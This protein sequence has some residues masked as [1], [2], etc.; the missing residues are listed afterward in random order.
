MSSSFFSTS[1]SLVKNSQQLNHNLQQKARRW[2]KRLNQRSSLKRSKKGTRRSHKISK[3]TS[4]ASLLTVKKSKKQRPSHSLSPRQHRPSLMPVLLPLRTQTANPQLRAAML[5]INPLI[6]L[7]LPPLMFPRYISVYWLQMSWPLEEALR[8]CLRLRRLWFLSP[9]GLTQ[10][11]SLY[12]LL[13]LIQLWSHLPTA[14]SAR[15]WPST[16]SG[17]LKMDSQKRRQLQAHFLRCKILRAD[18]SCN[19][20]KARSYMSSSSPRILGILIKS[21]SSKLLVH[22]SHSMLLSTQCASSQQS[23]Q[24]TK[25]YLWLRKSQDQHR[26]QNP[27]FLNALW[28]LRMCL[29]LAHYLS[30]RTQ[31]NVTQM[32]LLRK[33]TLQFS[34]SQ[35]MASMISKPLSA[36]SHLYP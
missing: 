1:T 3:C 28:F 36:W 20:K 29:T 12:H 11:R 21:Y 17:L 23:T 33:W 5:K 2:R 10:T 15:R 32:K 19:Q 8:K 22:S 16:P 18:G 24:T 13:S 9:Y 7:L 14:K 34:K 4:V 6:S 31:K 27:I 25:M 35:T 30:A 26:P